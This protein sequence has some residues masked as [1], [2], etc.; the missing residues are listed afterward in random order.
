MIL[1]PP[2]ATPLYSSAASDVYKR[3]DDIGGLLKSSDPNHLV[4]NGVNAGYCGSNGW[5]GDYKT[6]NG[7]ASNDICDYH[8]YGNPTVAM[9][10]PGDQNGLQASITACA[11]LNKAMVVAET[12]I[13]YT[14]LSPATLAQRSSD[15]DAKFAAQFAA[16]V[17]G[18]LMWNWYPTQYSGLNITT[19]DPALALLS[20]Y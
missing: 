7:G 16:G 19:N 6:V 3:Q 15:F 12:G 18:E 10:K 9:P 17:Q 20:K 1:R 4:S 5:V 13:D 14:T 11:S 8:D 2:R